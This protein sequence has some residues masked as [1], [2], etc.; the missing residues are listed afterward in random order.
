MQIILVDKEQYDWFAP[1]CGGLPKSEAIVVYGAVEES[2]GTA[3]GALA[4]TVDGTNLEIEY[5]CVADAWRRKGVARKL[6]RAL[7][8]D[9]RQAG[10]FSRVRAHLFEDDAAGA[11]LLRA[12]GFIITQTDDKLCH[13]PISAIPDHLLG[14]SKIGLG[15]SVRLSEVPAETLRQFG[16]HPAEQD[17]LPV[18]V[19]LR[20]QD[21]HE[22]LSFAVLR[23]G[24][25]VGLLLAAQEANKISL[26][27][28]YASPSAPR[29]AAILLLRAAQEAKALYPPETEVRIA[30][31]SPA[32]GMLI[33]KLLPDTLRETGIVAEYRL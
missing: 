25:I 3:V 26:C 9:A 21:Y 7:L 22:R 13:F 33:D 5:S 20:A 23:Q 8:L 28:L 15:E 11:A 10:M 31:V 1:F 30:A 27:Y 18:P 14:N 16:V 29:A 19:P 4:A 32:A 12:A 2:D 17:A 24:E 6:L